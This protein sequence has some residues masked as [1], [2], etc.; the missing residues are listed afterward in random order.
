MVTAAST[1]KPVHPPQGRILYLT[2]G[3]PTSGG[4]HVNEEHVVTL[5]QLGWDAHLLQWPRGSQLDTLAQ[6]DSL[7]RT[8]DSSTWPQWDCE[9]PVARFTGPDMLR[10]DDIVVV[11]EPW[12]MQLA[13]FARLHL[14]KVV[15][16]QNPYYAFHG[17]HSM[18]ALKQ[19]GYLDIITCSDFT[20]AQL[21]KMG[22]QGALHTVPPQVDEAFTGAQGTTTAET[23]HRQMQLAYM[24]RKRPIE[25]KYVQGLFRALFP[26]WAKLPW[27]AIESMSR[28]QCAQAMRQSAVFASLGHLEGLGLPPLEAMASGCVV[29]GFTGGG[30]AEYATPAN[31]FWVAEGDHE[32]FCQALNQ[33]LL[34]A[35]QP[36]WRNA[37]CGAA[38]QALSAHSPDAFKASLDLAWQGIAC[39]A[40]PASKP[41]ADRSGLTPAQ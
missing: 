39:R 24:P 19:A 35:S 8:D 17:V 21:R 26:Q 28:E 13:Y 27:L 38:Q 12:R 22:W 7:N 20:S 34:C 18:A 2:V 15:H 14:R 37:V 41:T 5:R 3:K 29:A 31:G 25:A 4:Q 30:G 1:A 33:A 36:V 16:C 23:D 10:S 6:T 11:P 9:A 32:G 40:L